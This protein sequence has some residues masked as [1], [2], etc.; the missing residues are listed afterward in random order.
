MVTM[1]FC[2]MQGKSHKEKS[3]VRYTVSERESGASRKHKIDKQQSVC[4]LDQSK[5]EEKQSHTKTTMLTQQKTN[6]WKD[7]IQ[8]RSKYQLNISLPRREKT[9]KFHLLPQKEASE[10]IVRQLSVCRTRLVRQRPF[11]QWKLPRYTST[12][13]ENVSR[14]L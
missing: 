12:V 6:Y 9:D 5:M 3:G 7:M 10:D 14:L 8:E 13:P 4:F 11:G 2:N 1:L